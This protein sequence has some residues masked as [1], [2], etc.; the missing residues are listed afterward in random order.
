MPGKSEITSN[1]VQLAGLALTLLSLFSWPEN[2]LYRNGNVSDLGFGT[3]R[4][5]AVCFWWAGK[6]K[7]TTGDPYAVDPAA[8][9]GLLRAS[10]LT[11]LGAARVN[12]SLAPGPVP[13]PGGLSFLVR[14]LMVT[15]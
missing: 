13:P 6:R 2:I 4:F 10:Q 7:P 9:L 3:V 8:G 12:P 1:C 11:E 14:R 15:D 5:V